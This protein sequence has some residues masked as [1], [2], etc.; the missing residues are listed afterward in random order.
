MTVRHLKRA[1]LL[2]KEETLMFSEI[3]VMELQQCSQI[4][5]LWNQTFQYWVGKRMS[6]ENH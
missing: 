3:F 1:D 2:L 5:H 6:T 4:L